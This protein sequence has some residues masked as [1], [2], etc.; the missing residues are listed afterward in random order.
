MRSPPSDFG[1]LKINRL[2]RCIVAHSLPR[3]CDKPVAPIPCMI[4]LP[5]A[6]DFTNQDQNSRRIPSCTVLGLPP[7]STWPNCGVPIVTLEPVPR[8]SIGWLKY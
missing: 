1:T 4:L 2:Q 3:D 7:L 8:L 6:L 5:A